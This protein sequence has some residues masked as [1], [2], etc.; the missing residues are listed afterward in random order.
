[1]INISDTFLN[2][3]CCFIYFICKIYLINSELMLWAVLKLIY[4]HPEVSVM[5]GLNVFRL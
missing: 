1:M 2:N 4:P 3:S 5:K